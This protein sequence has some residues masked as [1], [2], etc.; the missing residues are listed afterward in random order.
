VLLDGESQSK[1]FDDTGLICDEWQSARNV[2]CKG[3]DD[4]GNYF[5]GKCPGWVNLAW[6]TTEPTFNPPLELTQVTH[7]QIAL[8]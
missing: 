3:N 1:T 5:E 8:V 4:F 7:H 6:G 2:V